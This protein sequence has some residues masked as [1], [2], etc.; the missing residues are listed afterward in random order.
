MFCQIEKLQLNTNLFGKAAITLKKQPDAAPEKFLIVL[1]CSDPS[2]P[3]R[4]TIGAENECFNP[5]LHG[6]L[7]IGSVS[8]ENI[9]ID[10]IHDGFMQRVIKRGKIEGY[11]LKTYSGTTDIRFSSIND[12]YLYIVNKK[13]FRLYILDTQDPISGLF[14]EVGSLELLPST[15]AMSESINPDNT[16]ALYTVIE[17]PEIRN[18]RGNLVEMRLLN[19]LRFTG[20]TGDPL[21]PVTLIS[22]IPER[23]ISRRAIVG[24]NFPGAVRERYVWEG[25]GEGPSFNPQTGSGCINSK[26]C[27]RYFAI[28]TKI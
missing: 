24:M 9:N 4:E 14:K 17:R 7:A 28:L 21:N 6:K 20:H 16:F 8:G 22:V 25:N 27:F 12:R 23:I 26:K 1:D 3:S 11:A 13:E 5:S 10:E 15:L 19:Q 18:I 2:D